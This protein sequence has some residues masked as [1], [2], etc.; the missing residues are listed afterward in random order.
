MADSVAAAADHGRRKLV[1]GLRSRRGEIEQALLARVYGIEDPVGA[2]PEYLHG[3]RSAVAAAVDYVLEI[4][5]S[6]DDGPVAVPAELLTQARL[7]ARAEIGIDTVLRRYISGFLLI[8]DFVL[9]DQDSGVGVGADSHR[10][11]RLHGYQLDHLI[12]M[13]AKEYEREAQSK[14]RTGAEQ[15]TAR[16]ER[17]L[18]GQSLDSGDLGYQM[19]GWHVGLLITGEAPTATF[20]RMA[21]NLDRRLLLVRPKADLAWAWLGGRER[22]G[23]SRIVEELRRTGL[24]G[25]RVA[26]GEPLSGLGGWRL[27]HR[28]AKA[29]MPLTA[30]QEK[31]V[32]RYADVS[33]V[34]SVSQD[35][36]ALSSLQE[37]Y[38]RPLSGEKNG[39]VALRDT[40][41]AYLSSARSITSA[42]AILGVSR[43]TVRSRLREAEEKLGCSL[44]ACGCDLEIALRI[45]QQWRLTRNGVENADPLIAV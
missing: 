11:L 36:V 41:R 5:E 31:A 29:A 30:Q 45:D 27:S 12:A 25:A 32:V 35:E 16:V 21:T 9:R 17:L 4:L 28:Q 22:L 7:A 33:V 39:G 18:A 40:L 13:I 19:D 8:V 23:S 14:V 34:A 44:D 43:Q 2:E 38:L 42:A 20:Q 3:L 6:R 1:R 37:L 24:L 15:R 26:V 10:L